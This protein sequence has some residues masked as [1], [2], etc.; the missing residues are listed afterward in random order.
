[1]SSIPGQEAKIPHSLWPK[2]KSNIITNS[3]ET[4]KNGPHQKVIKKNKMNTEL[5]MKMNN[6]N[7]Q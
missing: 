5:I 6:I 7:K 1:M 4:L 3:I 2:N